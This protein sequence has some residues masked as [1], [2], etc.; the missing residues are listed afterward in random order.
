MSC[1]TQDIDPVEFGELTQL[2]LFEGVDVADFG[3]LLCDAEVLELPPGEL[4]LEKDQL[5]ERLFVLLDGRLAIHLQADGDAIAVLGKGDIAGDISIITQQ[6]TSAYVRADTHCRLLALCGET[7][8]AMFERSPRLGRNLLQLFAR[9]LVNLNQVINS[10]QQLQEEY[11]QHATT[12]PLTGLYNRRWLNE[13]L[14]FEISRCQLRHRPLA[15]LIVDIDHF[16]LY[17]DQHGHVAGDQALKAVANSVLIA[18]RGSDMAVRYGGEE[19]VVMLPG[20]EMDEAEKVAARLHGVVADQ[21]IVG[22]DG[23]ALPGVTISIGLAE[24]APGDTPDSLIARAD[25]ALYRAKATGRN[26]TSR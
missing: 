15:V 3:E 17:N 22:H 4:L 23:E 5:N 14:A 2:G 1:D 13:S 8:W 9:R 11:R 20:A 25:Q 19:I 18:L 6:P 21:Y 26:S 12:D 24:V 7:M 10:A 16:K